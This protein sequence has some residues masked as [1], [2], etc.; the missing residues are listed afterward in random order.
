[1]DFKIEKLK[2]NAMDLAVGTGAAIVSLHVLRRTPEKY[3][4]YT[5]WVLMGAGVLGLML[6]G[7]IVQ[8]ASLVAASVGTIAAMN[9]IAQENGVPAI[10]GWKGAINKVIPQLDGGSAG[11]AML[12]GFGSVEQMNETL[13][14]AG[15]LDT[16]LMAGLGEGEGEEVFE[17]ISGFGG[18]M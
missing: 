3:K 11:V 12:A 1:M 17:Q 10:S 8:K 5:G 13:L 7:K 18:L 9:S 15:D 4:K 16:Q 6:G 14:G 2:D